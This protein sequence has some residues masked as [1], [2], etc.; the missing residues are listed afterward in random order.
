MKKRRTAI[1]ALAAS[2]GGVGK[3]TLTAA[4]A[5]RAAQESGRVAIVDLDP[6]ES[7]S[8]WWD[9]RGKVSN[10][11]LFELGGAT[12]EAIELL[13]A[14]GW[15]W[16]F[17]DTPPAML[18]KIEPAII[19]ADL[20]LIPTRASA[21]DVEAVRIVEEMCVEHRKP[22]AFVLNAVMPAWKLTE[23]TAA[24]LRQ[25]RRTVLEPYVQLRQSHAAAMTVGKSAPEVDKAKGTH[26]EINALWDAVKT[27]LA[28]SQKVRR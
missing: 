2:K 11:H 28:K 15:E 14:E 10:P 4:L 26:E 25:N 13:I 27:A 12:S 23:S 9:R 8:S 7:L 16:V 3:T 21:L 20:V 1:I 17:I 6:Q 22:F 24:Y 19:A 5:V 18:D